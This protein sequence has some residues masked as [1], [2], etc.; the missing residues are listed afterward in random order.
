M[1]LSELPLRKSAWQ[2]I[3]RQSLMKS[4]HYDA[5][6]PENPGFGL[7]AYPLLGV[8]SAPILDLKG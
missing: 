4:S 8:E 2:L 3:K 6:R 5:F 7:V 1:A